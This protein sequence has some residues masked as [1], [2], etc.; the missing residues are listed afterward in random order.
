M[1]GRFGHSMPRA[2]ARG[3]VP[4]QPLLLE[5]SPCS[6]TEMNVLSFGW[7]LRGKSTQGHVMNDIPAND[8]EWLGPKSLPSVSLDDEVGRLKAKIV[9]LE[10]HVCE[11]ELLADTDPLV[12]LPNRRSIF[13]DLERLIANLNRHGGHAAIIFVDV[14]GLKQI[15]DRFGHPIGDAALIKVAQTLVGAVRNSD[16]VGRLSGDEFIILLADA[17]ELGAWNM[18]LRVAEATMAFPLSVNNHQVELSIAVGVSP[19]SVGDQPNDVISRA[20]QAMYKIKTV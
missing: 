8:P 20:D 1:R 18:A 7:F 5:I 17:D 15:N 11:L 2:G 13:R 3:V 19:I 9:Q 14:D 6:R 16:T 10:A 4:Q 12:G